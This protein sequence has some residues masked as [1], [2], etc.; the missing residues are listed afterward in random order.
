MPGLQKI[1][2][3]N[4]SVRNGLYYKPDLIPVNK[5]VHDSVLEDNSNI[6]TGH[7]SSIV[8]LQPVRWVGQKPE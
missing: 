3:V 7:V 6:W 4:V 8:L 1:L 5:A 2:T